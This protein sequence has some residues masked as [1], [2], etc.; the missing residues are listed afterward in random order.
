VHIV[1]KTKKY[2]I[3]VETPS[4]AIRTSQDSGHKGHDTDKFEG[5]AGE[6]TEA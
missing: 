2:F 6:A 1:N 3:V 5:V 4:P